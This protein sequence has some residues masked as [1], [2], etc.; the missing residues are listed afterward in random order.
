M[1]TQK[2]LDDA[3]KS[4]EFECH[5]CDVICVDDRCEPKD[6]TQAQFCHEAK[7]VLAKYKGGDGFEHENDYLG[8]NGKEAQKLAKSNVTALERFLKKYDQPQKSR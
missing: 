4:P 8:C 6:K 1:V 2:L 5:M 7:Y 3:F